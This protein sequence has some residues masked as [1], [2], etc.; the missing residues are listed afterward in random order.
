MRY[1]VH[2][3]MT[4]SLDTTGIP[5]T[6]KEISCS[7]F[8]LRKLT[9][10]QMARNVDSVCR[11]DKHRP[12]SGTVLAQSSKKER[13]D[14]AF[15]PSGDR[16]L[17]TLSTIGCPMVRF[18]EPTSGQSCISSSYCSMPRK[19]PADDREIYAAIFLRT[20]PGGIAT[21]LRTP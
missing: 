18:S 2:Q 3:G 20:K 16:T 1:S 6:L 12:S 5:S 9:A 14:S 8:S 19:S 17:D 11:A 15:L 21:P 13:K 7:F 10:S 4:A